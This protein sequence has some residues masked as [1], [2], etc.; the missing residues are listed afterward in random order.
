VKADG[1]AAV[2]Q[3]HLY[4]QR[5]HRLRHRHRRGPQLLRSTGLPHKCLSSG[6]DRL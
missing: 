1:A 3:R 5:V 2:Q 6:P 4:K